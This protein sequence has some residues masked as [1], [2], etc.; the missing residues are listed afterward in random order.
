MKKI[1]T[2]VFAIAAFLV[3]SSHDM[4]L[5]MKSFF[6]EPNQEAVIYLYNGTFSKSENVITRNRMNDVSLINGGKTTHPNESSWTEE[7]NQTLLHFNSG[8]AG[9]SIAALSTK[10]NSIKLS[11]K[12]FAEYLVHDGIKD[13]YEARKKSG[14]DSKEATEKYSKHVKAIFQVGDKQTDEYKKVLG[15][16]VEFVPL[17]NPYAA[18]AGDELSFKLL[19]NGKP[20]AN[21]LVYGSFVGHHHHAADGSHQEAVET[22]TDKNGIVKLKATKGQWYL[23]T[24]NMVKS[25][26]KGFDYESNWAT[27]TFEVK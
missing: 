3:L 20:L 14:E 5:K 10:P 6:V 11:A 9:T 17:S 16:P 15:Y 1:T 19:K 23:R 25:K 13:V 21:E 24:I 12:D 2:F 8:Q 22:R 18:K 26:E 27:I 4:Y 7:N